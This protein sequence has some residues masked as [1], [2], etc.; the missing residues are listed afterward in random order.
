M[1]IRPT[2]RSKAAFTLLEVILA[3]ALIGLMFFLFM[4]QLQAGG[5]KAMSFGKAKAK[6]LSDSHRRR[7][8]DKIDRGHSSLLRCRHLLLLPW[9]SCAAIR[10]VM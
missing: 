7:M 4:R 1:C 3:M 8:A 9:G 10:R 5:G 2:A 6:M